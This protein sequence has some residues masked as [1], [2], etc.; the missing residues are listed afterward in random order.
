MCKGL[1]YLHTGSKD[2]IY[3]LDLKPANILL[4]KDMIP[5]I[6]DFGMS[7][8][9]GSINTCVTS[10][11]TGTRGY[12][13]PEYIDGQHI[14]PKFDVYSLGVIIIQVMAGREGYYT[15]PDMPP[16]EFTDLVVGNWCKRVHAQEM[17]LEALLAVQTCIRIALRC[18]EAKRVRR[19]TI[20][21]IVV[22][23]DMLDDLC[24]ERPSSPIQLF[25]KSTTDV[26]LEQFRRRKD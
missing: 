20:T 13:P 23:L 12:M 22:E 10:T 1:K 16:E 6:G 9:L 3:H 17:S 5:K 11:F 26:W 15:C 21:E 2:P 14:S 8:L 4:D 7:R 25:L 24:L 19:P 18:I